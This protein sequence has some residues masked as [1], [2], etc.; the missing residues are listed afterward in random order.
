MTAVRALAVVAALAFFLLA[1]R[2]YERR[3]VSRL[4]LIIV[5]AVAAGVALLSISPGL[6][7]PVFGWVHGE[8]GNER[9]RVFLL[10][11]ALLVLLF[12]VLAL[13]ARSGTYER[14]QR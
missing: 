4:S 7:D 3:R 6:F 8:P 9:R 2:A 14:R 10:V 12:F 13:S 5:T 1:V 11:V